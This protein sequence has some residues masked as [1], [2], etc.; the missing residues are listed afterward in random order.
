[1]GLEGALNDDDRDISRRGVLNW[2]NAGE[3]GSV[4]ARPKVPTC[5]WRGPYN[6]VTSQSFNL[7]I[8]SRQ[9]SFYQLRVSGVIV[10]N[11]YFDFV[12]VRHEAFSSLAAF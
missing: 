8:K 2:D 12:Q 5:D 4:R 10:F 11:L 3:V 7:K 1:M 6:H 9:N